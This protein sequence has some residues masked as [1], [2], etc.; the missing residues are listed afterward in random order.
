M[1]DINSIVYA[2]FEEKG[3][4][5]VEMYNTTYPASQ[6]DGNTQT[7]LDSFKEFYNSKRPC[8]LKDRLGNVKNVETSSIWQG[9]YIELQD[10]YKKLLTRYDELQRNYNE[11]A[12]DKLKKR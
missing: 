12:A 2:M 9:R 4:D 5:G 8:L 10:Q 3:F 11:L 7:V 1:S 6:D